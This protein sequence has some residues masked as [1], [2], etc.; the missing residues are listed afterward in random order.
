MLFTQFV[1][2]IT[3]IFIVFV[4]IVLYIIFL[5]SLFCFSLII[6]QIY[7]KFFNL[8]N[9]LFF[10]FYLV[11]LEG[12]EPSRLSTLV[13]KTNACYLISPQTHIFCTPTRTRTENVSLF[14]GAY[15]CIEDGSRTHTLFLALIFETSMY[16]HF[17]TPTFCTESGTR[18]RTSF[19]IL[20][21]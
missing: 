4:F 11:R 3:L 16:Y 18:T 15:F 6:V 9:L 13:S 12:I 17:I 1:I 14:S 8:P 10:I 2:V 21:S 5:L 19:R 7:Y 20:A